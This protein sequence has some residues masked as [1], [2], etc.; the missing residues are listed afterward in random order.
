MAVTGKWVLKGTAIIQKVNGV[1][2]YQL[3]EGVKSTD[4]VVKE[5]EKHLASPYT[6]KEVSELSGTN[7]TQ[8]YPEKPSIVSFGVGERV[9]GA[10]NAC[11]VSLKYIDPTKTTDDIRT[12]VGS[13]KFHCGYSDSSDDIR[14]AKYINNKYSNHRKK[15]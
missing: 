4:P 15:K 8:P 10:Y 13:A 9:D 2:N 6:I 14:P 5:I 1:S 11:L 7:A 3:L 12:K